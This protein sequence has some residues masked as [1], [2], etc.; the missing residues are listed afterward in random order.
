MIENLLLVIDQGNTLTKLALFKGEEILDIKLTKEFSITQMK[1]IIREFEVEF[2]EGSP[3]SNAIISSVK[4]NIGEITK[5]LK[6]IKNLLVMD[7]SIPLPII[8]NYKTP[9]T[10]GLDRIAAVIAATKIF[11]NSDLLIIE[12]GTCITYDFITADQIYW[13]GAIS[14]GAHMRLKALNTFTGKLPLI[15]MEEGFGLIGNTT[16]GSILSGVKNGII[17]EINGITDRYLKEYPEI[18][19]ILSGGEANYFDKYLKNNI[20]AVSNLVLKGL[21][22]IFIYNV[23]N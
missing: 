21:K 3:L 16:K 4:G 1:E 15:E 10:L 20:F 22:D 11:K 8:N 9:E 6:P 18:K 7:S 13:G 23:K 19:F 14:P 2:N 5:S 12:A 17:A